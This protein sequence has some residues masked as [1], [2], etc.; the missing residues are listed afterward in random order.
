MSVYRLG[1]GEQRITYSMFVHSFAYD[2]LRNRV[3][4]SNV[5]LSNVK[6]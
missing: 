5:M 4:R 2:F 1:Y 6:T 3:L